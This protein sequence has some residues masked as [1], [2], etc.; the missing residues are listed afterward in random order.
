MGEIARR[1]PARGAQ[2]PH[3]AAAQRPLI[4]CLTL[5]ERASTLALSH[6]RI[7]QSTGALW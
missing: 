4:G 2:W 1:V 6:H 7:R 3:S 5:P